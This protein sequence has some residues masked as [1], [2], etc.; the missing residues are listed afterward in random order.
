MGGGDL[1]V[2]GT[3]PLTVS[4]SASDT[5]DREVCLVSSRFGGVG[6]RWMS[7]TYRADGTAH[8]DPTREEMV[9]EASRV[10]VRS[11]S[12]IGLSCL[13][14]VMVYGEVERRD[15]SAS[16]EWF[17]GSRDEEVRNSTLEAC[18]WRGWEDWKSE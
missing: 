3:Q 18:V 7:R 5:A 4:N 8:E 15:G 9:G 13:C 14:S 2:N 10:E 12:G 6:R 17:L 16:L 1:R 11:R